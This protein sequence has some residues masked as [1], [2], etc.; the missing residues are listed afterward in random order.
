MDIQKAK[1]IL[2][3]D[4]PD[5]TDEEVEKIQELFEPVLKILLDKIIQKAIQFNNEK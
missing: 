1:L 3:E 2:K 4:H 5:I